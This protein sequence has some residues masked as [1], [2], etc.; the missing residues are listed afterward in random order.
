MV[1]HVSV[2]QAVCSA[3]IRRQA[4][5]RIA[6]SH[7]RTRVFNLTGG[8]QSCAKAGFPLIQDLTAA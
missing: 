3:G 5:A 2:Q 8:T 1:Q 7:G 6:E 4:A